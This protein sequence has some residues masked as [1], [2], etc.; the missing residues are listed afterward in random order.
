MESANDCRRLKFRLSDPESAVDYL[1]VFGI[2]DFRLFSQGKVQELENRTLYEKSKEVLEDDIDIPKKPGFF[3][4][5]L[6][7]F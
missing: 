5:I 1:K 7:F 4:R 6:N 2:R 3:N